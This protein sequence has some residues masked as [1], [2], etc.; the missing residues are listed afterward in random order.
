[1][2][3]V[4]DF[5]I[6]DP[7]VVKPLTPVSPRWAERADRAGAPNLRIVTDEMEM[8]RRRSM[9]S[10]KAAKVLGKAIVVRP[11][12]EEVE[13]DRDVGYQHHRGHHGLNS[14]FDDNGDDND[15]DLNGGDEY[16]R[17]SEK[18]EIGQGL[19]GRGRGKGE[20]LDVSEKELEMELCADDEGVRD[21]ST[22]RNDAL[23]RIFMPRCRGRLGERRRDSRK[24]LRWLGLA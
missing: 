18:E 11:G 24:A 13:G 14:P 4:S 22:E 3:D 5:Y 21:L 12:N 2:I 17:H 15:D 20:V 6:P 10:V 23:E 9:T 1:L 8:A 16:F 19:G 7:V